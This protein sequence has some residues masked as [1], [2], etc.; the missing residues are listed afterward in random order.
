MGA[1]GDDCRAGVWLW[2][3]PGS[4]RHV[5]LH[6]GRLKMMGQ[7]SSV[8]GMPWKG[9][10]TDRAEGLVKGAPRE[11]GIN[12]YTCTC[13]ISISIICPDNGP[14]DGMTR[15]GNTRLH[16]CTSLDSSPN[17]FFPTCCKRTHQ[18]SYQR[19]QHQI[20]PSTLPWWSLRQWIPESGRMC[21]I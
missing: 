1:H 11:D 12:L 14:I 7:T 13:S 6:G 18:R 4:C 21:R 9:F 15:Q 10:W 19:A 16:K 3:L 5:G 17:C 8:V 20:A 2:Q